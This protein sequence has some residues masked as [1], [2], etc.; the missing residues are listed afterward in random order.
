ML[1]AILSKA[2]RIGIALSLCLFAAQNM[3]AETIKTPKV[4]LVLSGGGARGAAHIGVLR[5]LERL[6]VPVDYIAGTSMGAVVG[7]LYAM[8][9]S[10]NDVE[11][12]LHRIDWVDIFDDDPMRTARPMVRK[13][14]DM[15]FLAKFKPRV[16][17]KNVNLAPAL[18]QGQKLGLTLRK[19]TLPVASLKKFDLL[20]IPFRAV[21]TDAMTGQQVILSEGDLA[22]AIRA[23]M[24]VPMVFAPVEIDEYTLIDG[25]IASNTPISVVRDMGADIVIAVTLEGETIAREELSSPLKMLSQL[26]NLLTVPKIEAE[27]AT[28]TTKDILIK[29]DLTGIDPSDFEHMVAAIPRGIQAAQQQRNALQALAHTAAPVV[30]PPISKQVSAPIIQFIRIKTNAKID[31]AI[32]RAHIRQKENELLDFTQLEA[33]I[34]R[35]YGMDIFA[36]VDYKVIEHDGEQGLLIRAE[37]KSWGTDFIQGGLQLSS[38]LSGDSFFNLGVSFTKQPFN[39]SNGK[40]RTSLTLGEEPEFSTEFYQPWD[41]ADRWFTNTKVVWQSNKIK[42]FQ[43]NVAL[44][45]FQAQR[46]GAQ[47]ILGR[48]LG[49]WGSVAVA[50]NRFVGD[51][52]LV[53]GDKRLFPEFDFDIGELLLDFRIDNLDNV[54]FPRYGQMGTL[55]MRWSRELLGADS[56]FEQVEAAFL[57]VHSWNDHTVLTSLGYRGSLDEAIPI[58]SRYRLG[59]FLRL[60]G[61]Q[62]NAL[63]GEQA[64]LIQLG[65]QYRYKTK[66]MPLYLGLSLEFGNTWE[67]S[68]HWNELSASGAV[69]LG[70]DTLIGPIYLGYGLHENQDQTFYLFL[71]QPWF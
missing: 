50:F 48:N 42:L 15:N 17:D 3:S 52:R 71:G 2:I 18:I 59:G 45:E 9:L 25:G 38:D 16:K 12:E 33:D 57:Q 69:Y 37:E 26:V 53:V 66:M 30:K 62:E 54:Y 8:G 56:N 70:A 46:Y 65:Y 60:S 32:L 58:Q 68:I 14:E 43:D 5:V 51:A 1:K 63:T 21:A 31:E 55:S 44:T 47:L 61:L 6:N 7:G 41:V 11:R 36:Y 39:R 22:L 13:Q 4:G 24:A 27:L 64:A 29:A 28:L 23:S 20:P 67:D 34:S 49:V 10:S 40:W 19:L 35:I